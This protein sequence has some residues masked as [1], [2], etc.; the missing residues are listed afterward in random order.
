MTLITVITLALLVLTLSC[1]VTLL[2]IHLSEE[3]AFSRVCESLEDDE[4]ELAWKEAH[5]ENVMHDAQHK[6][7]RRFDVEAVTWQNAMDR[8]AQSNKRIAS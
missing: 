5:A 6:P 7:V 3:R 4:L 8:I 1:A 2:L